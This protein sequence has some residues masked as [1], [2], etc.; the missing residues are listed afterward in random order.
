MQFYSPFKK[1]IS[2]WPL[3]G[4]DLVPLA[5]ISNCTLHSLLFNYLFTCREPLTPRS[6]LHL[7]SQNSPRIT[8]LVQLHC[9][10]E[11]AHQPAQALELEDTFKHAESEGA[12]PAFTRTSETLLQKAWTCHA[13]LKE[14]SQCPRACHTVERR[15]SCCMRSCGI[16]ADLSPAQ[17]PKIR[18]HL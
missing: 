10:K 17:L 14:T 8:T 6:E 15:R 9:N 7:P 4:Y 3:R 16:P 2:V 5:Y 13:F 18:S 11:G 1:F 12:F